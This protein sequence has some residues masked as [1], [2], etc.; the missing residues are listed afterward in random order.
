MFSLSV[1]ST[2]NSYDSTN[3]IDDFDEED[4]TV[5]IIVGSCLSVIVVAVL[6]FYSVQRYRGVQI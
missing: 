5:P 3:S 1:R 4:D 2:T 6:V